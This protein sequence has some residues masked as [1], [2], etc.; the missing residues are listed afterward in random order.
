MKR[1]ALSLLLLLSGL[2]AFAYYPEIRDI[3]IDV[4]LSD[5]GS[6]K[7]VEVW[8][9]CVAS[10]TEWYLVRHNLGDIKI[11][12]LSVTDETGRNYIYEGE[13]WDIERSIDEKAGRCGLTHD[14]NDYEICW[15]VGSYGDHIFTV[16]YTMSNVVK[17][18][19]DYD[20]LHMQFISPGLS[21]HPQH[22]KVT[23]SYPGHE[24]TADNCGIWAFG[25]NGTDT[26]EGGDIVV[27]TDEPFYIDQESVILL[28]RFDKGLFNPTSVKDYD[29]KS[30]QDMAFEGSSYEDYIRQQK[31]AKFFA[32]FMAI[33]F[34][35]IT[36][37]TVW[38]AKRKIKK[39]N[40][41]MFGVEKI[42]DIG[43]ERG[44]PFDGDLFESR[45]VM[46]KCG[47]VTKAN[48]IASALILR[49]IKE[50]KLDVV[51]NAKGKIDLAFRSGA[52]L[53]SLSGTEREF[54]DM[55]REASG[56]DLVLQS[57]E[58]SSWSRKHVE[59]VSDWVT[60]LTSE[61]SNRLRADHFVESS[62]FTKE[63]QAHARRV[64]GFEKYLK[65]FT[66]M[67]QRASQEAVLWHDYIVFAAL[68]G[69]ADKVAKELKDINP[70]AFEE[71]VG[72]D[73]P[74]MNNVVF[75]SNN[76]A[77][78]ITSAVVSHAQSSVS[79]G[80]GGGFSSFGG[81]GGFSGGGFGG[82]SR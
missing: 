45:Y 67:E 18:L 57:R 38:V 11:S 60:S 12:D 59:R 16:S 19:T 15:G 55:V 33:F 69:I 30:V 24:L 82:G 65:D 79:V 25:F 34:A 6:A 75:I 62:K 39:R 63:G 48:A 81:G 61:G 72:M 26:F 40:L 35:A 27:E 50:G 78:S 14:G 52:D 17:A 64:I 73:Y 23:V 58:F 51:K 4:T 22:A 8:D 29:F 44:I 71:A 13:N 37:L 47:R 41:N 76:M 42:K 31:E 49:F 46:E 7:I 3:R 21:S 77:N 9:V 5:N 32:R 56:S 2:G 28:T 1:L 66:L 74:T 68:Y 10:G 54:Y 70:Q 20:V 80:G 53:S 36:A 43:W